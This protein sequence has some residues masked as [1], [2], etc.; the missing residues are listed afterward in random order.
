MSSSVLPAKIDLEADMPLSGEKQPPGIN[1]KRNIHL[2]PGI[3]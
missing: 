3:N 1:T 2:S